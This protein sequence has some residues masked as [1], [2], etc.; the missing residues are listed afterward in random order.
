MVQYGRTSR[1]SWTKSVWSSF[2][3]T[4]MGQ[5]IW[6]NP[7]ETWLGENFKLGSLSVHREKGIFLFAY[8]DDL[9]FGWKDIEYWSDVESTQQRSWFGRTNIFPWSC[10][11]VYSK[12]MWNKQ[13]YCWQLPI[14][15]WI[16][17]FR[18]SNW[19]IT[20]LGKSAYFFVVIWLGGSCKEMCGTILWVS[21]QDDATT[22]QGINSM[23]W[24]PSFQRRRIEI[25]LRI[26][27]SVLSNCSEML[28]LGTYWKTWC[29][30]VSEQTCTI[31][32][33]IYQSLWQTLISFDLLHS[34][35]M[36]VQTELPCGKHCQTMQ[37]GI[38]SR[39]RF[40]RRSWGFKTYI[41]W[42]IFLEAIRLFQS[43]GCVRNK[44]SVSQ[45]WTESEIISSDAGLRL[46]GIPALD[47]WDLIVEVLETRIRVINNAGT[48]ART[49]VRFVQHLTN[50]QRERNL[51]EWWTMLILYFPNANSSRQEALLY[52]FEDNNASDQ[53]D[54][55]AKKPYNE[56]RSQNPQS[57]SW[58]VVR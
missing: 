44:T 1:S 8:V 29:S 17:N 36:W 58:L 55:K 51:M 15:V 34:S 39:L 11:G 18:R 13:R 37:I 3:R 4:V 43:V 57:C 24:W 21:Q 2:G 33:K 7:I 22:L 46:D 32:H 54:H 52:V 30:L 20:M 9:K 28:I 45:S 41:R 16:Q 50:F 35:Y 38:V 40:C 25:C 56:T 42:N 6:E 48:R 14:N 10:T 27:T 47:L 31:D 26:A 53:D 23:H 5:T 49:Y 19:K 12:T